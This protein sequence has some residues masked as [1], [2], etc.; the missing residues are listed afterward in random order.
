MFQCVLEFQSRSLYYVAFMTNVH[1]LWVDNVSHHLGTATERGCMGGYGITYSP[2]LSPFPHS[3]VVWMSFIR[4][5]RFTRR[6]L[7]SSCFISDTA[8]ARRAEE[9]M[10]RLPLVA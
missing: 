8:I 6:L 4:R 1:F 9:E 3:H 2:H 7:K 5:S 10:A